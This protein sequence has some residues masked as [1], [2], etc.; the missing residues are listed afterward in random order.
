MWRV[1]SCWR[2]ALDSVCVKEHVSFLAEAQKS[3]K[4]SQGGTATA[5][6][7]KICW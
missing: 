3:N 7:R 1:Q 6:L 2:R 4:E 5:S